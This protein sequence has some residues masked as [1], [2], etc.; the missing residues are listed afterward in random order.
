MP[1]PF[2][3]VGMWYVDFSQTTD[4]EVRQLLAAHR[5]DIIFMQSA[6]T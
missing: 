6:V 5:A 4:Q 2:S 1:K 3:S